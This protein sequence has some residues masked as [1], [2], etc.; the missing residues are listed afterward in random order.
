MKKS[1]CAVIAVFLVTCILSGCIPTVEDITPDPSPVLSSEPIVEPSLNSSSE[2]TVESSFA[3]SM[4]PSLEP[5]LSMPTESTPEPSLNLPVAAAAEP[6]SGLALNIA[7]E[8]PLDERSLS[9]TV[10]DFLDEEQQL[11]YR[12][13]YRLYEAMFGG[14]S[15]GIDIPRISGQPK[16]PSMENATIAYAGNNYI[17]STGRYSNWDDFSMVIYSVYTDEFWKHMNQLNGVERYVNV[18]GRMC[19]LDLGRGSGR[20]YLG[21]PDEFELVSQTDDSII[22]TLIGHYGQAI[23]DGGN[24][25]NYTIEYPMKLVKTENGWRFEEFHSALWEQQAL[26]E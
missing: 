7:D 23:E 8:P 26:D 15:S 24:G 16:L 2:P 5:S 19:Y 17:V 1:L 3:P 10:P 18:D 11:L 22:F 13:A 9:I 21:Q 25:E 4:E 20:L 6:S 14:S 12:K